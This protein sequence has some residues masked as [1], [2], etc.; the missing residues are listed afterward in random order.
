[1][2]RL[3]KEIKLIGDKWVGV[4]K[5]IPIPKIAIGLRTI[6]KIEEGF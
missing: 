3:L 4:D 2:N 1:L 6:D 5:M